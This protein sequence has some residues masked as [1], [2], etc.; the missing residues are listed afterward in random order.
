MKY[1]IWLTCKLNFSPN[2]KKYLEKFSAEEIWRMNW[3]TLAENGFPDS[4]ADKNLERAERILKICEAKR[5][6]LIAHNS[7]EYPECLKERD[8]MPALLYVKGDINTLNDGLRV[9]I[10][11]TRKSSIQGESCTNYLAENLARSGAVII[12]G[13]AVGIDTCA[14]RA[15][16][17]LNFRTVA[18]LGCDIDHYY[19]AENYSLFNL[20]AEHG[21]VI[22]EYPPETNARYFP[23]RNRIIA[24]LSERL[25]VAE[26][27]EK[28][29][30]LITAQYA[31]DYG[32]P[33]F[34]CVSENESFNGCREL[35]GRGA[36]EVT[37]YRLVISTSKAVKLTPK[38]KAAKQTK[39]Q[40]VKEKASVPKY[41][42]PVYDHIIECIGNG[43]NTTSQMIDGKFSVSEIL[44][45]I[46][47]LELK[48]DIVSLPGDR[49]Q[50]IETYKE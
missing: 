12:S 47:I 46:T 37:G 10:V 27:P 3:D 16:V 15:A 30:A 43:R 33:V 18:V 9:G 19:P 44:Q 35:V 25:I 22:S 20:I 32:V 36:Y 8:G 2:T 6:K 31:S 34:S 50:I 14:L 28:S 38:K 24:A 4:L 13:G 29:G 40:T 1:L 39:A 5:I 41:G 26:A 48:G 42:I 17:H 21:A 45:T 23:M 7:S 49:Y 11:G